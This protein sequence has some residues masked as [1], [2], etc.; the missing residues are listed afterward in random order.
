[1]NTKKQKRQRGVLLTHEGLQKI[2][3]AR[4]E[5]E[6]QENYG[7]RFTFEQLS[8]RTEADIN[9]LKK[10]LDGKQKVDKRTLERIFIAFNLELT[11]SCYSNSI[12]NHRLDLG[13]AICTSAFY[14]RT[15]QLT[16]LEQ[17]LC[18][19]R[20]RLVAVLG[21]GGIGKTSLSVKLAEQVKDRFEYVIWRSLR[22]APPFKVIVANLIQF[23]SDDEN[24]EIN[25]PESVSET[26]S[27]LID[28]LRNHR[29][30]VILDNLESILLSGSRSGK[31][32]EGYEDY[33]DLIGRV[34]E[35]THQSCLLLTSREKPKEV[36]SLEGEALSIRSIRLDGLL[37]FD[38]HEI[39]KV[40]G[41]SGT[42]DECKA[43][44]ERYAGNPL[45]LKIVATTIKDVFDGNVTEF[46]R[47]DTV[48]FGDMRDILSQQFERLSDL[49][50]DIIY[51]LAI[52]RE[53]IGISELQDDIVSSI[54]IANL[55]EAV[56]SLVRRSLIEKTASLFTLQPVVMEYVTNRLIE[57][58]CEEIVTENIDLFRCHALLKA[59]GKDYVRDIQVRLIIQP[60]IDGLLAVLRSKRNLENQLNQILASLRDT[61]LLGQSYTA[62]N[63]LNL[64]C[65]LETDLTGYDFSSLSVWQAD[66]RNV[67]LHD[68]NFQNADLAK[69]S[70]AETFG[71]VVSVAFSPD[72]KL[73]ATGDTNSE[74]RLRQV[75]DGKQ[76]LTCK[77]HN[78]WVLS[79][80]FHPNGVIFSS[81][82][83]DATIK[84]WDVQTGQCLQ[85][86]QGHDNEVWSVAF[87]PNGKL[88]ASGS[89]DRTIKLWNISTG[90]CLRTF[91][92]HVSWVHSVAFTLDGQS[93]ISGSDDETIRL[94]NISTG[95]C[96]KTFQGHSDG[97]RSIAISPDGRM[98]ASSSED[99]S[100]KLWNISTGKCLKTLQGHSN[101][102]YSVA[103]HPQGDLLASVSHDQ[104]VKLWNIS[105]GECLRTFQGHS[106]WVYSVAFSPQGDLLASGSYDQTVRLWNITTGQCLRKFQGYT[107]QLLSVAFSPD[108]QILVS[109]SHDSLVRLWNLE[110]D[111][112][113]RTIQ[114][115]LAAVWSVTFSPDG[116]TLASGSEDRTVRLWD[117][118]TGQCLQIFRGHHA[119]VWSV[120]FSPDGQVL[121]SSSEDRTVR[122][123]DIKT[124]QVVRILQEHLGAVWSIA[125]SPDGQTLASGSH[126]QT[127]KLWDLGTGQCKNTLVGHKSWVWSVAFS[128][129]GKLLA[130]TSPDRTIRLWSIDRNECLKVLEIN[131]WLQLVVFSPDGNIL[132]GC[133][134]DLTIQLWDVNKNRCF[135]ALQGHTGRI[136]SL[137][138][139]RD[140]RTLVTCGEDETI[141][142]WD[143]E[144]GKCLKTL[145]AEKPYERMNIREVTGLNTSTIA[146]LKALGA[147]E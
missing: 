140:S 57:Q 122:L 138:F 21:M 34:G 55:L 98:L 132:G 79:L 75:T 93:L 101:E 59:T 142:Q 11:E 80:A 86:L 73:L 52:N 64:F 126:D 36:A 56:E 89:D 38:C 145:R 66:L 1:M 136:W 87:S 90:E 10:V 16:L 99:Q 95:E 47:Q 102:I 107:S 72:G 37:D 15:Q 108:R 40:K 74:I 49:E 146:T 6:L 125:F 115:H 121:A 144:T 39:L 13:E 120:A 139:N 45:A 134:R 33:G 4:L 2:Q 133:S 141:K 97:I 123:W 9:T 78:S 70:F 12:L 54:P 117:A 96:V 26:V 105:T 30:L 35:V 20:C 111:R 69:S 50:K 44:I 3:N 71:G 82:S 58:V 77:G 42:K 17:L 103:F 118:N 137:T 116:Q 129:D 23:L 84:L 91:Q 67:K 22:E 65:H 63:I 128:P 147:F 53:P 19:E 32:R 83:A 62:G 100:V 51:W 94:W 131:G 112:V 43:I 88:L 27:L 7:K 25:L 119:L 48:V 130:T 81:S 60:V 143:I 104:S 61:L 110:T 8:A 29:C 109:G 68:V 113:L 76:I 85:T 46:L 135:K 31:Y 18:Q 41:L 14:G 28:F 124:G 106:S 114:G 127:V 24:Q 92:G 5:L